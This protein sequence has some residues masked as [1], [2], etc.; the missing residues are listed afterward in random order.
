MEEEKK[1]E[2]IK[3]DPNDFLSLHYK[4]TKEEL[5]FGKILEEY[6]NKTKHMDSQFQTVIERVNDFHT[7]K[8]KRENNKKSLA[9]VRFKD[10]D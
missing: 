1:E 10:V 3:E 5:K 7:K 4:K 8:L 2:E 9:R 6:T